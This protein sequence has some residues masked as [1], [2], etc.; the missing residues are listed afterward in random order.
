MQLK[1][2][3]KLLYQSEFGG[4]HMITD[5]TKSLKR[6][7]EEY[8]SLNSVLRTQKTII[9]AIGDNI[10]RIYLS[11][12]TNGLS[13]E[14]LNQMFVKSAN[15]KKGTLD[16]L[17][18]KITACI[19]ACR[20]G[21][22]PF[23]EEKATLFFENWKKDGYPA[24][25]HSDIYRETYHPA[26][27]VIETSYVQ[28]YHIIEK[29]KRLWENTSSSSDLPIVIAI[30]GMSGSGKSTLGELLNKNY[31]SSNLFHMDDYFL[32]PCQR[33]K[34]RLKEPGG[35]IDYERF[36]YEILDHLADKDGL[37]YQRYDCHTQSLLPPIHIPWSPIVIIEGSYS[38][39]P[40][41]QNIYNLRIF[42]EIAPDEQ[43]KRILKRNGEQ[44]FQRFKNEWIPKENEYFEKFQIK[45][46]A[47]ILI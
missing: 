18:E 7:Q 21:R 3:A 20:D 30:D 36:R 28:I 5:E 13:A 9:E 33:T 41:F 16:G 29:I 2:V 37:T 38:H 40:Y 35:N 11:S 19:D 25:R 32:R 26:Y 22:L 4:G 27:R 15:Q 46:K 12:L 6:I 43:E 24:I 17:E 44:M 10:C 1:D 34:Q 31:P 14:V 42:C 45:E 23:S 47:D 8:N 39:H